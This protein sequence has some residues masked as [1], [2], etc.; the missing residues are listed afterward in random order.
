[1]ALARDISTPLRLWPRT[2]HDQTGLV[3]RDALEAAAAMFQSP[4]VIGAWEDREE[5]GLTL[6]IVQKG[7]CESRVVD[8]DTAYR[9]LVSQAFAR[10]VFVVDGAGS[11]AS[12]P[13]LHPDLAAE[14]G[15]SHLIAIPILAESIEGTVFI[16]NPALGGDEALCAGAVTA[17]LLAASIDSAARCRRVRMDVLAEERS[18]VARDLHDGLLQSFTGVVLQLETAHSLIERDPEE[19]RKVLTRLQA[20]LMSDQRDLRAY[21]EALRPKRRS[22]VTFDFTARLHDLCQR[23]EEQWGVHVSV[24][25]SDVAPHVGGMLGQET[26]RLVQEAVTNAARHGGA[27]RIDV[28]IRTSGDTLVLDVTD[29]GTGLSV[30]GRMTLAE[31]VERGI[32]PSSLGERVASLNGTGIADSS[33]EGFKLEIELPLGWAGA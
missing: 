12:E 25:S 17:A 32:G 21:V 26:F 20:A 7:S 1:M 6:T 23:F 10:C 33:E 8:D 3:M 14:L 5:P 4:R 15:A 9:P 28:T 27:S 11:G 16:A 29:N 2:L 31:M 18:R 13:V 24:D 19:A 22:E 30:H